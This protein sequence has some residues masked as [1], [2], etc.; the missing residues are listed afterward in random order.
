MAYGGHLDLA[1]AGQVIAGDGMRA[2]HDVLHAAA[3]DHLAAVHAR[4]GADVDDVVGGAHGVF[5][6]FDNDEGIAEVAQVLQR[7]QQLFVVALVQ[8]D[9]RLVQNVQDAREAAADLRGEADAL[10]LAARKRA[11]A[12][13]EVE[14]GQPHAAQE[15]EAR[16]DLL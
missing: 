11:G 13:R 4:T 6:V 15:V 5:V 16:L 3:G 1:P 9:G 2:V 8:A 7:P 12:A 10:C 14:V